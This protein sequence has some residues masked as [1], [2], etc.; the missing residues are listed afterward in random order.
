VTRGE[1][2]EAER[3]ELALYVADDPELADAIRGHE[4]KA[5]LGGEWLARV[6][7]DEQL[8]RVETS[9][10][11]NV[12]RGIGLALFFGGLLAS[13]AAPVVGSA[14]LVGGLLLLVFSFLRVR[15]K[16]HRS[17]PYK[18]IQR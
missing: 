10:R 17:D 1:V 12:E 4:T 15:L 16:T 7:A 14:A 11:A 6:S 9:T 18:D 2:S 5:R 3:E 13:F 8:A